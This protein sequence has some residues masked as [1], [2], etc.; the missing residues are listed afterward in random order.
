L[1]QAQLDDYMTLIPCLTLGN[2][3]SEEKCGKKNAVEQGLDF[4]VPTS[5]QRSMN[6][7][8]TSK[9]TKV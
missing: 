1:V 4:G 2:E 5:W 9:Q 8:I 6:I 7:S 3:I